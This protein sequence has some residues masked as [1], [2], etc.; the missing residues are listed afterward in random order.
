[1][2]KLLFTFC[3]IVFVSITVS[4]QQSDIPKLIGPY[5]GQ[6]PPGLTPEIFAP[7]IISFGFHELRIT[8]SPE[9]D[10]VFYVTC[11]NR[12]THR[13]LVHIRSNNGK[14]FEPELVPFAWDCNNGSPSFSPD[15]KRVYFASNKDNPE[16]VK[17]GSGLDIWYIERVENGWTDP[18]KM[19]ETINST[20]GEFAPS[21]ASNGNLYFDVTNE[22]NK[23][24]IYCSKL[25]NGIYYPREKIRIDLQTDVSIG[26]SFI[27]PDESYLLFQANL[28][29]GFGG[30]DIYVSFN[31]DDGTWGAPINLGERINSEFLEIGPRVSIDGKYLFFT[32]N[33]N[34]P[35]EMYK[36]KNYS[37]LIE[38]LKS[39][40]NG[41]GTIYWVDAKIIEKLKPK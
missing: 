17:D 20:F 29:E 18:I 34:H 7:G 36:G 1:M 27:A 12:Y 21:V 28:P 26:S 13:I 2:K 35:N 25:I 3:L 6:K 16:I 41:Y 14:W 19:P 15:G 10:D 23:S 39:P 37:E 33:R 40:Q 31:N 11:A 22:N 9:G 24:F 4:A 38:M 30:N 5:L 8:F 32:S